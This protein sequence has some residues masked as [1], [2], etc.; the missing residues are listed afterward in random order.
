MRAE[1][2]PAGAAATMRNPVPGQAGKGNRR[3]LHPAAQDTPGLGQVSPLVR[4]QP[5]RQ[6]VLRPPP[7]PDPLWR[8]NSGSP[9]ALQEAGP[10][11]PRRG[12]PATPVT[13]SSSLYA[14]AAVRY[15]ILPRYAW[16]GA[17]F[18]VI[19]GRGRV[20]GPA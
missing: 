12:V 15:L 1:G 5:D 11:G 8:E 6:P 17:G 3:T 13:G 9:A 10:P 14:R 2:A 4:S 19:A 20:N 18:L 16:R 7:G